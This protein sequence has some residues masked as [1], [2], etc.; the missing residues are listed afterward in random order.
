VHEIALQVTSA[1]P[2]Y[3]RDEEIPQ[4]VLDEQVQAATEKARDAGKPER[5]LLLIVA[6]V[7]EKYKNQYVLLRQ[8]YIRDEA[9]TISQLLN[10]AIHQ[11]GENIVIRRFIRW[12]ICPETES[13]K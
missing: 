13:K 2:I 9:A 10:Q 12:E 4:Q 7:L 5:I 8:V 6:G 1:A 3:V 11:T